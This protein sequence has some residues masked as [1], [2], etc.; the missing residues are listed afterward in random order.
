MPEGLRPT[1]AI[2][3]I[4]CFVSGTLGFAVFFGANYVSANRVTVFAL[5]WDAEIA[6]AAGELA[7]LLPLANVEV[8]DSLAALDTK[9]G[10]ASGT[11]ILVGHGSPIGFAIAGV[12]IPWRDLG[13]MLGR[14]SSHT[15]FAA[16]CY[17]DVLRDAIPEK[18][19]LGFASLVDVDEAAFVAAASVY[20]MRGNLPRAEQILG[21]LVQVMVAKVLG[22]ST[23]P[24][25]TLAYQ[26]KVIRSIWHVKYND[27]YTDRVTYTHPD[28]Y[29][30]YQYIGINS[31]AVLGTFNN[32]LVSGHMAKWRLDNAQLANIIV[33]G[34]AALGIGFVAAL[35]IITAGVALIIGAILLVLGAAIQ[36]FIDNVVRD[37]AGA[38]WFWLQNL[39]SSWWGAG[40]DLKIG[41][42]WWF[43]FQTG[44]FGGQAWPL[45]YGG[46]DLGIA[47]W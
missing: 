22:V 41:K 5:G 35:A 37:E 42:T 32:N 16:M 23:H 12:V 10:D 39:W 8:A 25:A 38:G 40:F 31:D 30:H 4:I 2:L 29:L 34:L 27:A 1:V 15:V 28:T 18:R 14:G 46:Q 24:L 36:W 6:H 7:A 45:W 47:G 26:T 33:N 13:A 9:I 20:G 17:S 11:V 3:A 19:F 43:H 21:D 44:I